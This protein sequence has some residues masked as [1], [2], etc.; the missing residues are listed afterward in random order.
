MKKDYTKKPKTKKGYKKGYKKD[1]VKKHA[2]GSALTSSKRLQGNF[3]L[4]NTFCTTFEM[5]QMGYIGAGGAGAGAEYKVSLQLNNMLL[6]LTPQTNIGGAPS[7][8]FGNWLTS[9]SGYTAITGIYPRGYQTLLNA[10]L[11]GA[12]KVYGVKYDITVE[13]AYT[14][15]NM[16][17]IIWPNNVGEL[18]F[19]I[20]GGVATGTTK[21]YDVILTYPHAIQKFCSQAQGKENRLS[22]YVDIA[23][24]IG[25]TKQQY[26]AENATYSVVNGVSAIAGQYGFNE[27]PTNINAICLN[28][29][30][31]TVDGQILGNAIAV[32]TK[33]KY[34]VQLQNLQINNIT[35]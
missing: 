25:I 23:T 15:D 33:L 3:P 9:S 21:P 1:Y 26:L 6:P 13:P 11:Y 17:V 18:P 16:S 7:S 32:K 8:G 31:A 19:T 12:Y 28:A 35:Y 5:E 24:L 2:I 22:G 34:Y 4:P 14:L 20:S 27:L 30:F 10:T 29:L